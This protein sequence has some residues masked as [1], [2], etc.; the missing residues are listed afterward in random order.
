MTLD[1]TTIT[2]HRIRIVAEP[3]DLAPIFARRPGAHPERIAAVRAWQERDDTAYAAITYA[4][5]WRIAASMRLDEYAERH[6]SFRTSLRDASDLPVGVPY[7]DVECGAR[8]MVT[9]R[10]RQKRSSRG[11]KR[12]RWDGTGCRHHLSGAASAKHDGSGH[13]SAAMRSVGQERILRYR[14]AGSAP[15]EDMAMINT[16]DL[17]AE[18]NS[19]ASPR[20]PKVSPPPYTFDRPLPSTTR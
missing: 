8:W 3:L 5:G 6:L 1:T 4:N 12:Q 10:R 14:S 20:P 11:W 9:T 19:H 2:V 15:H 18:D 16:N 17:L 7:P 13:G